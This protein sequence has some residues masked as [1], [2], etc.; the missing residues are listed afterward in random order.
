[1]YECY[2]ADTTWVLRTL[3]LTSCLQLEFV[4]QMHET[5]V[6]MAAQFGHVGVL[7]VLIKDYHANVMVQAM[8][9][10]YKS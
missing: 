9:N 3:V 10:K 1:M 6:H 8:V 2:V 7:R 4:L 5:P